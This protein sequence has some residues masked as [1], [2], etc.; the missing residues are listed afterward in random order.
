M[1]FIQKDKSTKSLN[2]YAPVETPAIWT[3]AASAPR[4]KTLTITIKKRNFRHAE[5]FPQLFPQ[6]MGVPPG[7][8]SARTTPTRKSQ[9]KILFTHETKVEC[10]HRPKK[11][12]LQIDLLCIFASRMAQN[13]FFLSLLLISRCNSALSLWHTFGSTVITR[14]LKH[15]LQLMDLNV[16]ANL[17]RRKSPKLLCTLL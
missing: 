12:R 13:V 2:T 15:R 14:K 1:I 3:R 16:N 6:I 10:D 4:N 17:I 8:L 9:R 11:I 7:I 5:Q